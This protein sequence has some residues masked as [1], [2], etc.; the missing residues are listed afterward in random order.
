L[1]FG[2]WQYWPAGSP[3]AASLGPLRAEACT[4]IVHRVVR[5][6]LDRTL[7]RVRAPLFDGRA[8]LPAL[9]LIRRFGSGRP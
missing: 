8:S 2:D 6:F 9:S 1:H 4:T 3:V 7:R 5:E